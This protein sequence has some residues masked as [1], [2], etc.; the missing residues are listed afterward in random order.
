VAKRKGGVTRFHGATRTAIAGQG[1]SEDPITLGADGSILI[2]LTRLPAPDKIYDADLSW[3]RRGRGYVSFF[4]GKENVDDPSKLRTRLEVKYAPEAFV[5][6][7][8]RNSREFHEKMRTQLQSWPQDPS[9]E[10]VDG[11]RMPA[12]K[13]HSEWAN[14]DYMARSGTHGTIDFFLLPAPGVAR[15]IQ[16]QGSSGLTLVPVVRVM[17]TVHE[18]SRL[19]DLVDG[20]VDEVKKYLPPEVLKDD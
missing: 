12:E 18:L 4:F 19:L 13:D 16:G 7:F 17:M 1:V 3:V 10:V 15:F 5:R 9:L 2:N 14:F 11:A 6:H 20:M 8:W